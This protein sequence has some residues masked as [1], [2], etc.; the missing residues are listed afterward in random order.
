MRLTCTHTYI[1]LDKY[2]NGYEDKKSGMYKGGEHYTP[3]S[4]VKKNIVN[5]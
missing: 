1:K 3:L 5:T 2:K 4:T